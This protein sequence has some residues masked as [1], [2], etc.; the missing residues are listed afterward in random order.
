MT[1]THD[2]I[3]R[4]T[5]EL[6]LDA[7]DTGEHVSVAT[8]QLLDLAVA[9]QYYNRGAA[10]ESDVVDAL[11]AVFVTAERLRLLFGDAAVDERITAKMDSLRAQIEQ[12]HP[13]GYGSEGFGAGGYAT[14]FGE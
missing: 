12:S 8:T 2:R 13:R 6:A 9:L 4:R 14:R 7:F 1:E 3:D 5:I 10:S 11:A